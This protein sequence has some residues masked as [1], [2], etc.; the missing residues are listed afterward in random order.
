MSEPGETRILLVEDDRFLRKAAQA[1]LR[2][3]GLHHGAPGRIHDP[4]LG[5]STMA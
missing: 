2:R 3:S 4:R 5:R 1:T